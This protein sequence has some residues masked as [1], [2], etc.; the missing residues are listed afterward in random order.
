MHYNCKGQFLLTMK[1]IFLY[2]EKQYFF[3]D[4][5]VTDRF[6]FEMTEKN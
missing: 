4:F 5:L 6:L 3:G 2:P 1:H